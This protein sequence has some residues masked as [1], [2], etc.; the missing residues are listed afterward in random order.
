MS[1][2]MHVMLEC[3]NKACILLLHAGMQISVDMH[4]SLHPGSLCS[5]TTV[6]VSS[7]EA[8]LMHFQPV[9]HASAPSYDS[10]HCHTSFDLTADGLCCQVF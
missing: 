3:H 2:V 4:L 8:V 6:L 1:V 7:L 9:T 5:P 10:I